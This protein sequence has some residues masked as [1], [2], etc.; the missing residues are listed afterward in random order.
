MLE[1]AMTLHAY[2]YRADPDVPAFDDSQPLIIFDGLC[3]LCS[4]GIDWMLK[5]DPSGSTRFAAIQQPVPQALYRHYGLDAAAFNTFMVLHNG[6]PYTKWAG[7]LS[8]ARTLPQPWRALGVIGRIVPNVIG[9]PLYDWVQR[10]RLNWFGSRATCRLP[11]ASEVH[12]FL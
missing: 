9:N 7:V 10:N 3:V 11:N 4:T 2:S 1:K 5:R 12:R 8:A 6:V